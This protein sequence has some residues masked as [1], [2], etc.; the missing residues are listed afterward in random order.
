MT[1]IT[2]QMIRAAQMAEFKHYWSD[3]EPTEICWSATSPMVIKKMLEAALNVQ[4]T[5]IP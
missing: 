4:S 1:K 2:P 3:K 5:E